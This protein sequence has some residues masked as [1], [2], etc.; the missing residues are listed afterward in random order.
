MAARKICWLVSGM[1]HCVRR[2]FLLL[3]VVVG[4]WAAACCDA[5]VQREKLRLNCGPWTFVVD[6]WCVS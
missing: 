4:C 6:K 1:F 3:P 5:A 2:E